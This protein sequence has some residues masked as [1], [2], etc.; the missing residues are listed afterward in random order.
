[1]GFTAAEKAELTDMSTEPFASFMESILMYRSASV[2]YIS[3][4]PNFNYAF[5]SEQP[6]VVATYITNS[7]FFNATIEYFDNL[8]QHQDRYPLKDSPLSVPA[9]FVRVGVTGDAKD[10]LDSKEKIVLDGNNFRA[11]S[12]GMPRGIFSRDYFDF[13]FVKID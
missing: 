1:M 10:F 11:V 9:T 8:D 7:G 4:G 5:G 13:Y 12:D 6:D 3:Q 2:T